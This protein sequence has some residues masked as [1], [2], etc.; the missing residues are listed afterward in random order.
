MT[1]D[2]LAAELDRIPPG[3]IPAL[4]AVV[5]RVRR[6]ILLLPAAAVRIADASGDDRSVNARALL[7]GL[8]EL[9]VAPLLQPPFPA[10]ADREMSRLEDAVVAVVALRAQVADEL[11]ARLGDHRPV[12]MP[13]PPPGIEEQPFSRRVCDEAYLLLRELTNLGEGRGAFALDARAFLRQSD[14]EK[15]AE[16]ARVAAGQ[17][18]TRLVE[19]LEA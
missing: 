10:Q 7:G 14:E 18:F 13:P 17:A 9:A 12:P 1:P 6:E 16:I 2:E 4:R 19:D 8:A 5:E 11:R 3:N 15:D